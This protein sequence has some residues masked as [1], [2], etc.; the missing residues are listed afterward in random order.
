MRSERSL[1]SKGSQRTS[2]P[3]PPGKQAPT[4]RQREIIERAIELIAGRGIQAL[5]LRHL[6]REL[7]ITDPAIYRHFASKTEILLG[8]LDVLESEVLRQS[9]VGS[10]DPTGQT[11][12]EV[13]AAPLAALEL[14]FATLF[15]RLASAP[16]LA[17]VVFADEAF[18]NEEPLAERVRALMERTHGLVE[19]LI[20]RAQ[21]TGAVRCDVSAG[22]LA[23]MLVGSVRFVVRR[24]HV[25]AHAFDLVS[26]G[27]TVVSSFVSLVTG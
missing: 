22:V 8:V 7:G 10:V 11:D 1:T 2:T 16:P 20:E 5:T 19:D 25:S 4:P 6:A 17:A 13:A 3:L 15:E 23:T 18:L 21:E 14:R 27:G 12:L 26:E 9:P 24:W